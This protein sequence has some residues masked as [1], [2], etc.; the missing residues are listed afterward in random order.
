MKRI[1]KVIF[2]ALF[3]VL[4]LSV[5]RVSDVKA[6]A[7]GVKY[8]KKITVSLVGTSTFY[9]LDMGNKLNGATSIKVTS[10][11]DAVIEA[12]YIV[13]DKKNYDNGALFMTANKTGTTEITV[14]V[15]TKSKT[16][17]Y[18]TTVKVVKYKNPIKKIKIGKKN[19]TKK[20][21]K[22]INYNC[23]DEIKK[24]DII[25][26]KLK[27]GWKIKDIEWNYSYYINGSYKTKY[28][29]VKNGG[30]INIPKDSMP[31]LNIRVYNKKKNLFQD[32]FIYG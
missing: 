3:M 11:N 29:K 17:T 12:E 30:K 20:F 23:F 15:K 5:M 2:A 16:S 31:T 24:N 32:L 8:D 14:K 4:T 25:S 27:K 6:G 21:N 19:L 10:S 18:K 1:K 26:I 22:S 13:Y 9:G 7:I 28:R